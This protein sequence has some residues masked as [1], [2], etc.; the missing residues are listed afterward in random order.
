MKDP[1][2]DCQR[3]GTFSA[4]S[5]CLKETWWAAVNLGQPGGSDDSVG[6]QYAGIAAA[7]LP[8][9]IHVFQPDHEKNLPA[10]PEIEEKKQST[11]LR[12]A[13]LALA[14]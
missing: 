9:P 13:H 4:F 11:I 5:E 1:H 12:C 8:P 7:E 14:D 3:C 10:L 6:A 2:R